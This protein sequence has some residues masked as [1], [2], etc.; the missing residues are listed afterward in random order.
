M[1]NELTRKID[2]LVQTVIQGSHSIPSTDIEGDD[3]SSLHSRASTV[4]ID[5]AN[6]VAEAV[7]LMQAQSQTTPNETFNRV[8]SWRRHQEATANEASSA[9]STTSTIHPIQPTPPSSFATVSE[10]TETPAENSDSEDEL[11]VDELEQCLR[12]AAT[13]YEKPCHG[14]AEL[15]YREATAMAE[16]MSPKKQ[17]RFGLYDIQLKTATCCFFKN[18]FKEA[19]KLATQVKDRD[20]VKAADQIQILDATY[21]LAEILLCNGKYKDAE[22][23]CRAVWKGRYKILGKE[24]PSCFMSLS[25]LSV[26]M[27][28]Q[29]NYARAITYKN[30]IPENAT[31]AIVK[32]RRKRIIDP[33]ATGVASTKS[34]QD[35]PLGKVRNI[36]PEAKAKGTDEFLNKVVRS[37]GDARI[38]SLLYD[39]CNQGLVNLVHL[40]LT[41][42]SPRFELYMPGY[43]GQS[44]IGTEDFSLWWGTIP[45][46]VMHAAIRNKHFEVAK[47]LLDAGAPVSIVDGQGKG[48]DFAALLQDRQGIPGINQLLVEAGIPIMEPDYMIGSRR[49]VWHGPIV[50]VKFCEQ[51]LSEHKKWTTACYEA[52]FSV[53]YQSIESKDFLFIDHMIE[54]M[55]KNFTKKT[56]DRGQSL[57]T[58]ANNKTGDWRWLDVRITEFYEARNK[59]RPAW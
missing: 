53:L 33:T 54:V 17:E 6:D 2:F 9:T 4:L 27:E 35:K 20:T 57:A 18:N 13:E 38:G 19:E 11:E 16:S 59:P 42:W 50:D 10:M 41:G 45:E 24:H 39:A 22:R 51:W 30:M 5:A 1:V 28:M 47:L 36:T 55:G 15:F 37:N 3:Q 32:A 29:G 26:I 48:P 49:N 52:R 8:E 25:L 12:E 31:D 43:K 7:R 58:I 21:L 40:L 23:E 44:F 14:D 34:K 56:D 46:T